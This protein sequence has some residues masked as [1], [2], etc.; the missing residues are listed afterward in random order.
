MKS[1]TL[2][3][4]SFF[5]AYAMAAPSFPVG[6]YDTKGKETGGQDSPMQFT[7]HHTFQPNGFSS[8]Y[9]LGDTKMNINATVQFDAVGFFTL[10]GTREFVQPGKPT[11]ST[12]MKGTG[13]CG[14]HS[15]SYDFTEDD[16]T[17]GHET[18]IYC[19]KGLFRTG[20]YR[21]QGSRGFWE[22]ATPE[23]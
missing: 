13:Y 12:K 20:Y 15:C 22:E 14:E 2:L 18:L 6:S 8:E 5:T 23:K 7:G 10:E 3:F 4:F 9:Q 11:Q 16:G 1:I 17:I 21:E 19:E